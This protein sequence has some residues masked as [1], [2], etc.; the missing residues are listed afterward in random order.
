MAIDPD[1]FIPTRQSLLQRLRNWQDER[2]W[3][4]FFDTYWKLI[5]RVAHQAGLSDAE[6]QDVVQET[7]ISVAK[8]MEGFTYDPA[9]GSFKAW[10][11]RITQRRISDLLRKKHYQVGGKKFRREEA[12]DTNIIENQPAGS[13]LDLDSIWDEEW[14]RTVM[15]A[16]LQKVKS[17]AD[18]K[19][20]QIFHLHVTRGLPARQVAQ[21]VGVTLA[22]VYVAKYKVSN[23]LRK[24]I[25]ILENKGF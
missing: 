21:R 3:H 20:F 13:S 23:L 24:Q 2:G 22:Q 7:V 11:M 14:R 12:L 1:E 16:S 17:Q 6:A 19:Q 9:T 4:E 15:E 18:P 5:Y 8:Q 25:K 10:L